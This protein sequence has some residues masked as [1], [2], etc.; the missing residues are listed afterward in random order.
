MQPTI[1]ERSNCRFVVRNDGSDKPQI[2]LELFQE[3]SQLKHAKLGYELLGGITTE[4]A[5]KVA[6]I[7]NDHILNLFIEPNLP[8]SRS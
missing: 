2:I 1:T 4:Q 3:V 7:L 5:K 6:A 8:A